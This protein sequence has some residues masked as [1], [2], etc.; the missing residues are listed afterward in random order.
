MAVSSSS[1]PYGTLPDGRAV[2]QYTLANDRGVR[3]TFLD[4]GATL[5]TVEIPDRNGRVADVTHGY[6]ALA[7]WLGNTSYFG[8]TVGRYANRIAAGKFTLDGKRHTLA[9]NNSPGGMPCHLHGGVSGFDRKLWSGRPVDKPGARGV[10]F[11]YLSLDGEE[12]YPGNLSVVITCWLTDSGDLEIHYHATTDQTTIVNL[13][14]HAY[15][16]LTGD[17]RQPIAGHGLQLEADAVLAVDAGL[18]PTGKLL[19]VAGT[20]FDFTRPRRI[21]DR[22]GED[23]PL[24]R[25]G[26]GYDHC[27]V[28]RQAQ[29]LR[30]AARVHEPQSGRSLE[31][32]T[33]QPGVQLYT[34]NFLDGAVKGKGG[35]P[36]GFRTA[37]CLEP[38]KFPD[39]PNHPGFPPAT[40]RPGE[41][42]EH[43]LIYRFP[44]P[45]P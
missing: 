16:N 44:A 33:D 7:G 4:Y 19:A 8:A 1:S 45:S 26:G 36:Y 3:A 38:Q 27:W 2:K 10:E 22:I 41:T 31:L 37:F 14:N 13:T 15:W 23:H 30:L 25:L 43:T 40:L 6:D 24:L 17:P 34:G 35:V 5:A 20:P 18:I 12:N 11:S 29:G 39:A 21:G 9:T 32:L 28:L 42:Y